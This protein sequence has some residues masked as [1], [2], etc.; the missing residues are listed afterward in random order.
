MKIISFSGETG[1][2]MPCWNDGEY[3]TIPIAIS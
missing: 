1:K 2:A 3:L